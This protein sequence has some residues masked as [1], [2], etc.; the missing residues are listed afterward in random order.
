MKV[1]TEDATPAQLREFFREATGSDIHHLVNRATVLAK[2]RE[3]GIDPG[4]EFELGA[5]PAEAEADAPKENVDRDALVR[6][7]VS[8]GY[9]ERQARD[10][11]GATAETVQR[12]QLDTGAKPYGAGMED[13]YVTVRID[14][15]PEKN[16]KVSMAPVHVAVNGERIDIPRGIDWPIRTPFLEALEHAQRIEYDLVQPSPEVEAKL[17]PHW[18]KAYPFSLLTPVPY[19][20]AQ[21]DS[22]AERAHAVLAE[23]VQAAA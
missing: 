20:K 22:V 3:R 11:A 19:D 9:G 21:A 16:G 4:E 18:V 15:G 8:Q 5:A 1:R 13:L 14:P 17:V 6:A 7:L 23:R 10:L 12:R 2:L